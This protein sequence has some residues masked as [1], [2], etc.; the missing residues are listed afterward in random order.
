MITENKV[1]IIVSGGSEI[2][3]LAIA[4][5][6][7]KSGIRYAVISLVENSIFEKH[8]KCFYFKSVAPLL[9]C[10]NQLSESF[11]NELD[12]IKL[13]TCAEIVLFPSEDGSLRLLNEL[14][15]EI[16][17]RATFS[18]ARALE[19]GGVD[20]AE[21]IEH[22]EKFSLS[23][24][25]HD[26]QV[27]S[28]PNDALEAIEAFGTDAIFKP[29]LK[30]L[31]MDLSG[32]G[33]GGI[34]VITRHTS[35]E[36]SISIVKRLQNA[37]GLSERWVAQPRLKFGPG[38][39]RSVCLASGKYVQACQVTEQLKH[40]RMGGTALWVK[41][42]KKNNLVSQATTIT[43]ALDCVGICEVSFLPGA[44]NNYRLVE[45]NPRPWLQVGLIDFAGFNII[46]TSVAA[47]L[48]SDE[49]DKEVEVNIK[50]WVH[51]ERIIISIIQ[52]GVAIDDMIP[53]I[54]EILSRDTIIAGYSSSLPKM[55]SRL[56]ARN[57]RKLLGC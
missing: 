20:K 24:R 33:R 40:P 29:A 27:I 56:M 55:K 32:L 4:E 41:T 5:A 42:D 46:A 2:V 16:L 57:F 12:S 43:Q 54:K 51:L 19:M 6:A 25:E 48:N 31:N 26:A 49:I 52:G 1:I 7:E 47:L 21:V 39:E 44:D 50:S 38:M 17:K 13:K 18:R 15:D 35:D 30:P 45:L 28:S 11:L 8:S 22:L 37:W 23:S 14:R 9:G 53:L 3:S 34:K 10:W 36:S